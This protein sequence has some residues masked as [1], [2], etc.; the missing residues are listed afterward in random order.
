[1]M[2]P[3]ALVVIVLLFLLFMLSISIILTLSYRQMRDTH[4]LINSRM[5][6]L[7]DLTRKSAHQAGVDE[8]KLRHVND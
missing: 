4:Y 5:D 1:M 2:D 3:L 6:Q 7:I 8:E